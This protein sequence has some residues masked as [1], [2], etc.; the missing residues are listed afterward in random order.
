MGVRCFRGPLWAALVLAAAVAGGGGAV[1]AQPRANI[2]AVYD[3]NPVET[4]EPFVVS[5]RVTPLAAYPV[6]TDFSPWFEHVPKENLLAQT[7]WE[8]R[9]EGWEQTLTLI[10]F[11]AG[12][13]ALPPLPIVLLQGDTLWAGPIRLSVF[14]TPTSE[15]TAA[16]R[17]IKSAWATP[18]SWWERWRL[19]IGVAVGLLLAGVVAR[20]L[21]RGVKASSNT[22]NVKPFRPLPHEVALEQLNALERRRPWVHGQ[23][24][25]YYTELSKIIREYLEHR[26]SFPA[27]ESSTQETLRYCEEKG[28]ASHLL[29]AL[30]ELLG[31]CDLVK[32]ARA[33]P[34]EYYHPQAIREARRFI[35]QMALPSASMTK[36][37]SVSGAKFST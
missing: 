33:T 4:G 18:A 2:V 32:F 6:A 21:L 12:E 28:G 22:P 25:G 5:L 8:R 10:F 11:E 30:E 35:E 16:W 20:W 24:K 31:W 36:G 34:P 13:V 37:D 23:I 3:T 17:D 7:P 14:A 27:L 29:P 26:Y 9:D 15:E 1:L 19:L